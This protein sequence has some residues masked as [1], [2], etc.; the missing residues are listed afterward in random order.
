MFN[1]GAATPSNTS[2][3]GQSTPINQTRT[4]G[5]FLS[6]NTTAQ[7]LALTSTPFPSSSS[8]GRHTFS[9]V[10]DPVQRYNAA[11]GAATPSTTFLQA[12][13]AGGTGTV[14]KFDPVIGSEKITKN[15]VPT[16]VRT[17]LH[18]ICGMPVYEKKSMEVSKL[19]F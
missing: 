18:N 9:N 7:P 4:G 8:F 2:L 19:I 5:S 12:P 13:A 6:G 16:S 14:H 11:L 10:I 3:F 15:N 1:F 17:K